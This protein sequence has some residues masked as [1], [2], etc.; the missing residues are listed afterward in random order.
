MGRGRAKAK[1]VKVARQLKYNGGGTDL[2]RLRQELGVGTEA[3]SADHDDPYAQY[4]E[5]DEDE[6]ALD[7]AGEEDDDEDDWSPSR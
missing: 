4:D 6:D 3:R 7:D 5:E 2:D 1:Q